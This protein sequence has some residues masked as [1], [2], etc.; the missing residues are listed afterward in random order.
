M[1]I[2]QDVFFSFSKCWFFWVVRGVKVQKTVQNDKKS[3]VHHTSYLRNHTSYDC[4]LQYTYVK[5][6]LQAFFSFFQNFDFFGYKGGK[7][8]KNSLKWQKILSVALNISEPCIIWSLFML[9]M[10]KMIISPIVFYIFSKFWFL[11]LF[12][13]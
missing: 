5:W 3:F 8:G 7:K 4:H 6:Y 9:H 2:S 10:C 11:G 13:G 12:G 1:I